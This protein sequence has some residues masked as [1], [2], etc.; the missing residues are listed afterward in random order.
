MFENFVPW[1]GSSIAHSD[2][3][4]AAAHERQESVDGSGDA[5]SATAPEFGGDLVGLAPVKLRNGEYGSVSS[6]TNWRSSRVPSGCAAEENSV[7]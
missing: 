2:C 4:S 5:E 1:S 3:P 7:Y 6:N